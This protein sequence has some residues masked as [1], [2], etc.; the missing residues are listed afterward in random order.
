VDAGVDA[1]VESGEVPP[2]RP[3]GYQVRKPP[4]VRVGPSPRVEI[5]VTVTPDQLAAALTGALTTQTQRA[6]VGEHDPPGPSPGSSPGR[7]D[8]NADG[9]W[10]VEGDARAAHGVPVSARTLRLLAC[11]GRLRHALLDGRGAV[12]T[13]GRSTRYAT[14]AQT[15]ALYAR[16]GGCII[17]GCPVPGQ[18]CHVH[19][20]RAW[21]DGG[22]TD[23]D[24]L[25]LLCPRHH[26]EIHHDH[27]WQIHI[28]D[29]VPWVRP[30]AW[31][32]PDRPLMRN[33]THRPHRG[34]A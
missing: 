25:T 26:T 8:G 7:I 13:L 23:L 27:T 20:P 15:R 16:D 32:H 11:A 4:G 3:G 33:T 21:T 31:T 24:N 17:P 18:A 19:H 14:P 22:R 34:V 29:A 2:P 5:I 9:L 1:V 28:I 6:E 12:L 10:R 30:P